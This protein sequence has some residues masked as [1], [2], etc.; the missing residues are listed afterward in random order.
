MKFVMWCT[1]QS[2]FIF[3][4]ANIRHQCLTLGMIWEEFSFFVVWS[5]LH[6]TINTVTINGSCDLVGNF[7][8]EDKTPWE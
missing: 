1:L 6:L 4:F 5:C 7:C 8:K 2:T 3:F